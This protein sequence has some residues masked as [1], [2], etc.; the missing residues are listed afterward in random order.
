M[1]NIIPTIWRNAIKVP[2]PKSASKDPYV[3]LNYR[4]ISLLSCVYKLFTSLS[5][6]RISDHCEAYDYFVDEQNGLRPKSSCQDHK[7][8]ISTIIR[9]RKTIGLNTCCA[10]VDFQKAFDR[11]NKELLMYKLETVFRIHGR[12]FNMISPIYDSSNAQLRLNGL[13]TESFLFR[14]E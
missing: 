7:Y 10:F 12:L 1:K 3:S 4:G 5:N 6:L 14:Q 8:S 13:L 9:N 11:V 2:I